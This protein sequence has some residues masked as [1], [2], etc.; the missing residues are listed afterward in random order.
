MPCHAM[1]RSSLLV[2]S[3]R[4]SISTV[5]SWSLHGLDAA[6]YAVLVNS[7]AFRSSYLLS[8]RMMH[9]VRDVVQSYHEEL[10]RERDDCAEMKHRSGNM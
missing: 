10:R 9:F 5:R 2:S 8:S 6:T 3:H 4:L 7:P 1:L